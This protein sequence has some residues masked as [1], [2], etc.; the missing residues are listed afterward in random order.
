ME[1]PQDEVD[2]MRKRSP[3]LL[4]E[5]PEDCELLVTRV[6]LKMENLLDKNRTAYRVVYDPEEKL[7]KLYGEAKSLAVFRSASVSENPA[8]KSSGD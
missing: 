8:K 6:P 3:L 7:T 4:V 2:K 5:P 1:L